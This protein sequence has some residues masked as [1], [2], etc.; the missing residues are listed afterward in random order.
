MLARSSIAVVLEETHAQFAALWLLDA[1]EHPAERVAVPDL[2]PGAGVA[3]TAALVDT[4]LHATHVPVTPLGVRLQREGATL[5]F[6]EIHFEQGDATT[7]AAQ[8]FERLGPLTEALFSARAMSAAEAP[9]RGKILIVDD[10]DS[11]RHLLRTILERERFVVIAAS[12]GSSAEELAVRERPDLVIMDWY[13]STMDGPEATLRLKS[14]PKT[15]AIPVVMLTSASF[16]EDR[17]FALETGVQDFIT[18]PFDRRDLIARVEGQL[19][20]KY[21]LSEV[22]ASAV[23]PQEQTIGTVRPR[24][25]K[26]RADL[27]RIITSAEE[28]ESLGQFASAA[29][30]YQHAADVAQRYVNADLANKLYRLAGKMYL[31]WAETASDPADIQR[32]YAS[33]AQ[34]FSTAGNLKPY[35]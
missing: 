31:N 6:L 14:N 21:L 13:M 22:A 28:L 3:M 33:A 1:S 7:K 26:A 15:S 4:H 11:T 27:E 12:D 9:P 29:S 17:V 25:L 19:R 16:L 35:E 30:A 23:S 20:W 5:A 2:A 10:D 8:L 32:G 34:A 18:K 24:E